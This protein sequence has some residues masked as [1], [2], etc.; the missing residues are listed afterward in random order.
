MNLDIGEQVLIEGWNADGTASV[1][2]RG[3]Q[4]TAVPRPGSTPA[5]GLHRVAEVIG[6]RLVVDKI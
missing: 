5:T 4:W 1:R 3:A 2:F 6:N